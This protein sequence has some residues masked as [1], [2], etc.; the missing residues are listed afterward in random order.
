MFRITLKHFSTFI[1]IHDK[2]AGDAQRD[3]VGGACT[4]ELC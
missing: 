4:A 1:L 2:F 3:A